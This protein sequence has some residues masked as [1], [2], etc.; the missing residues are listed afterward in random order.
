YGHREE[1]EVV[2]RDGR[3]GWRVDQYSG[4]WDCTMTAHCLEPCT[5]AQDCPDPGSGNASLACRNGSSCVLRC[6]NGETCPDGM[7]CVLSPDQTVPEPEHWC[8]WH[9]EDNT[10]FNCGPPCSTHTSK[11]SCEARID[12]SSVV[13]DTGCIWI[14]ETILSEANDS[15]QGTITEHCVYGYE[16]D[17]DDCGIG[18][19]ARC[20]DCGTLV[21]Q[22]DLGAG[23]TS[24]VETEYKGYQPGF[25]DITR[26]DWDQCAL[27]SSSSACNCACQ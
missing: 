15:C 21:Y 19:P 1:G 5:T 27:G 6:D 20:G 16:C 12:Q 14:R 17:E 8:V 11:E 25:D 3:V 22:S 7:R 18:S 10:S 9:P 26:R 4:D 24:I 23:T 13:Y 2:C